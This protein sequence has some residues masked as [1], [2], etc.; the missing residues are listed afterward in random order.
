MLYSSS[1]NFVFVHV[2]KTAGES[3]VEALRGYCDPLFR[4]R[5]ATK[6]L[7]ESPELLARNIGWQ[8]YLVHGQHLMAR[9]IRGIMPDGTFDKAYSFG[10]VRNP[11]DWTVSAYHYARQ[12]RANPDHKIVQKFNGLRDYVLYRE[13]NFLRLQSSFLF[14]ENDRQMVTKIGRFESLSEDIAEISKALNLNI[15]LPKRNVSSRSRDWRSYYDDDTYDRVAHMYRK[16]IELLG[17][18][19]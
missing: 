4:S 11:W 19:P 2:W 5:V 8:P 1:K 14:D 6:L 3:I 18:T 10:F 7:R 9:D 12:T 17:Y 16:D 13:E 15:A